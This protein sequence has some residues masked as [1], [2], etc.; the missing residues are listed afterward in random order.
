MEGGREGGSA[1]VCMCVERLGREGD[2]DIDDVSRPSRIFFQIHNCLAAGHRAQ[3]EVHDSPAGRPSPARLRAARPVAAAAAPATSESSYPA[4]D[5][6]DRD[7]HPS[8]PMLYNNGRT[9]RM[10]DRVGPR[11][12]RPRQARPPRPFT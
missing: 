4:S 5:S 2:S 10:A 3:P 6:A 7:D 12:A 8:R 9:I 11:Q 1:C